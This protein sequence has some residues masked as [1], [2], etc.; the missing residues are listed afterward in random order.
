MLKDLTTKWFRLRMK[1]L[2]AAECWEKY[3]EELPEL[4]DDFACFWG[5]APASTANAP[6]AS[7][8]AERVELVY[9]TYREAGAKLIHLAGF[10]QAPPDLIVIVGSGKAN[11]HAVRISEA[12]A[13]WVDIAGL[14]TA[15]QTRVFV[16]H[17]LAHAIHYAVYPPVYHSTENFHLVI[18]KLWTEGVA[19]YLTMRALRCPPQEAL[20]ADYLPPEQL[21]H[22]MAHCLL[23]EEKLRAELKKQAWRIDRRDRFFV[24]DSEL[25]SKEWRTGYYCGLKLASRVADALGIPDMLVLPLSEVARYLEGIRPSSN[26]RG[27]GLPKSG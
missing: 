12:I 14:P 20:W 26:T 4:F 2:S 11:G 19:T 18:R 5:G 17:E 1:G 10:T 7:E 3:R 25:P 8:C 23:N 24:V 13:A 22:W 6:T 9:G 27:N 15:S 16:T 21:E